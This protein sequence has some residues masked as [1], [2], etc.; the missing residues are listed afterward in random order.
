MTA[1]QIIYLTDPLKV[2]AQAILGVFSFKSVVA[3]CLKISQKLL[4]MNHH[5]I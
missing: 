1:V 5:Y 3:R 4:R 2:P